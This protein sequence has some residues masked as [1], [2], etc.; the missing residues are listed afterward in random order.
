M[1]MSRLA[2]LFSAFAIVSP[3]GAETLRVLALES[4][5]FFYQKDGKLTGIEHDILEYFA[6]SR[7]ALSNQWVDSFAGMLER[8]ERKRS[9][10]GTITITR[11]APGG[12]TSPLLLSG[13]GD[14]VGG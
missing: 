12:W 9:A 6:K 3:A 4:D 14:S 5:S 10:A 2:I 1:D 8:V 13:S 7:N 11:S